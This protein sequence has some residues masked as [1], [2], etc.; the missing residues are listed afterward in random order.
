ME[1]K[2]TRKIKRLKAIRKFGFKTWEEFKANFVDKDD[3]IEL[4][5]PIDGIKA[6]EKYASTEKIS[7]EEALEY[8]KNLELGGFRDWKVPLKKELLTLFNLSKLRGIEEP[9]GYLRSSS[10][11]FRKLTR[12]CYIGIGR[13]KRVLNSWKV[14]GKLDHVWTVDL[15]DGHAHG[16]KMSDYHGE[17]YIARCV[18]VTEKEEK[19]HEKER[20]RFEKMRI[21]TAYKLGKNFGFTS[22]EEFINNIVDH[23][24]YI[25]FKKPVAGIRMF[26]TG[27]Y[28]SM[29]WYSAVYYAADLKL[30]CYDD[31][32]LPTKKEFEF[33]RNIRWLLGTEDDSC[34]FW[35]SDK[36]DY[37]KK[38][39]WWRE[40]PSG[41]A[42]TVSSYF[43]NNT[44]DSK[45]SSC[46]PVCCV[47][48]AEKEEDFRK[49][50]EETLKN[51]RDEEETEV[52]KEADELLAEVLPEWGF[53][54]AEEFAENVIDKGDVIE[55]KRP[56]NGV[57]MIQKGS[58]EKK[59][60]WLESVKYAEDL[61]FGGFKDWRLPTSGE[62]DVIHC[63]RI[64]CGIKWKNE[65]LWSSTPREDYPDEIYAVLVNPDS[66]ERKRKFDEFYVTCVRVTEER[67][68][69]HDRE[70]AFLK[71]NFKIKKPEFIRE[72]VDM[73]VFGEERDYMCFTGLRPETTGL[74][75]EILVDETGASKYRETHKL[76]L[77]M[78]VGYF[79]CRLDMHDYVEVDMEGN[80]Y[81]H[82][83][84][85]EERWS[86]KYEDFQKLKNFMQ[87]NKYA[88]EKV[89]QQKFDTGNFEHYL[90]KGG[91]PAS[92]AEIE[93]LN[94]LADFFSSDAGSWQR[95]HE[96]S[97]E[98]V[99]KEFEKFKA[100]KKEKK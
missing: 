9:Y 71:E 72:K 69:F 35:T 11:I 78:Y 2:M 50:R 48:G 55:F 1:R 16:D 93:H 3:Y 8:A 43:E 56:V 94:E 14:G 85:S 6:F 83:A 77:R 66:G 62:M 84:E 27:D 92:E 52:K 4:I 58:S 24:D 23:G 64:F 22:G 19:Y 49:K 26:E 75:F 42:I 70:R 41:M 21:D 13:K 91:E 73:R 20:K 76:R 25:E 47:R 28:K 12:A 51:A 82:A 79:R 30:G 17:Y 33:I 74:P 15:S 36:A 87:N 18:R 80:V 90:I 81:A 67:E 10:R 100:A 95:I 96:K 88:L 39:A 37:D 86:I 97:D 65:F 54:T 59:L 60:S 45:F 7:L 44:I 89:A 68:H 98:E 32:R 57:K 40:E 38:D 29:D 53:K 63:V 61:E 46:N 5:K 31:W 34:Y 99:M